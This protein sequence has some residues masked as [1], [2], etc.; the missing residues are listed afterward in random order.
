MSNTTR[1]VISKSAKRKMTSTVEMPYENA[2][3]KIVT[4]KVTRTRANDFT[5]QVVYKTKESNGKYT[6]VTKHEKIGS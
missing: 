4:Q 6:S 2:E 3:G 5:Q 1:T